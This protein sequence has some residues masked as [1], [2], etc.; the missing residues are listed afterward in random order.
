MDRILRHLS[1]ESG[2]LAVPAW[3]VEGQRKRLL[4]V[5]A[6][7]LP[8]RVRHPCVVGHAKCRLSLFR[9]KPRSETCVWVPLQRALR[10]LCRHQKVPAT[11]D[12]L[13]RGQDPSKMRN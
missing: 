9:A 13:H 12:L 5:S 1:I 2:C 10:S 8:A 3:R 7:E 11:I 6:P 4:E